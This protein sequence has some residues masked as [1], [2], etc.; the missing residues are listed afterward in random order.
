MTVSES[1]T[2]ETSP[3]TPRDVLSEVTKLVPILRARAPETEKLRRMHPDTLR[4]LTVAGVFRLTIPAHDGGYEADDTVV[5]NVLTQ[6]AR[7]CPSTGWICLI[8]LSGQPLPALL[9]D[10]AADEVYATGDLRITVAIA[11]TGSATPVAGG[12]RISGYWQ[13]NSGGV[14]SN[15]VAVGAL[16]NEED[17]V[18]RIFLVPVSQAVQLDTWHA[19][20]LAGSASNNLRIDDVFVPSSRTLPVSQMMDGVFSHSRYSANPYFNRP[21]VMLASFSAGATM[22]GMARGA[23]DVFMEVLPTRG[24]IT[25]TGWTKTAEAPVLHHQLARAQ[26]DLEAAELFQDKLLRQWQAAL[27]RKMTLF[28]RVQSRAWFGEITRLVRDC[29]TGLFRAS[30]ASQVVLGA[31]IQRYFRDIN[32]AAQHAHLQ[33]NSSSELYGRVLAGMAPDTMFL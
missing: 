7:G 14:H 20:G 1:S 6:I 26:L 33:P 12:Y 27:D 3:E 2:G 8:I 31:D 13:W 30:S 23:M 28:D 21:W 22:L 16:T 9:G 15:W 11:P 10:D 18:H 24:P 32:I 17:P 4:D 5:A 29:A 19:A 25:F